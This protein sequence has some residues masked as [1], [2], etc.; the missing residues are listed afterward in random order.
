MRLMRYSPTVTSGVRLRMMSPMSSKK[1]KMR[2]RPEK[3]TEH[4]REVGGVLA[5]D[6]VVEQEGELHAEDAAEAAQEGGDVEVGT[7]V[8]GD[9]LRLMRRVTSFVEPDADGG[10]DAEGD[11]AAG[12]LI[13]EDG[14]G[15]G[16]EELAPQ[17][18]RKG[19]SL[20]DLAKA[21]PTSERK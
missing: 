21:T 6:V 8:G 9:A 1:V 15:G 2:K 7:H 19:E 18:P 4:E 17:T 10:E 5:H 20:P 12:H 3:E 16:E 13:E 11:S 14:A